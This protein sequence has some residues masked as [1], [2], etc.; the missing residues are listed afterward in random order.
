M[1]RF[2]SLPRLRNQSRRR[3]LSPLPATFVMLAVLA[4]CPHRFDS[5]ADPIPTTAD[6]ATEREYRDARARY[7]AGDHAD[8][9]QRYATFVEHHPDDSLARSAK[10]GE[11]RSRIELG[12]LDKAKELLTPVAR[13]DD[14]IDL[15]ADPLVARARFLLG[16]ALV[17]TGAFEKGRAL[18]QSFRDLSVTNEDQIELHALF[19]A[20]ALGLGESAEALIELDRFYGNA[21]PAERAYI[22]GKA[23]EVAPKLASEDLAR[24]WNGPRDVVL[25]A[26]VGARIAD[27]QRRAGDA[28]AAS[29]IDDQ[30]SAARRKLGTETRSGSSSRP[31]KA[32]I[33]CV[34]PLSG[35]L[36]SLGDRALRGVLLGAELVGAAGGQGQLTVEVRDTGS[37]PQRVRAAMEELAQAGVLAVV[38]PPDRASA[39]EAS[40]AAMTLGLPLFALGPDDS[41]ASSL[42]FHLARPRADAARAAA[43]LIADAHLAR[44]AVLAPDGASGR[45][46][47]RVFLEA[48]RA[49]GLNIVAELHFA[50]N[51]TSFA[52]EVKQ[53][54][55]ARPQ[56]LFLPATAAQ[57]DLIA[58]QLATSGLTAMTNVKSSGHELRVFATADGLSTRNLARSGKYLQ[59]ATLLPPYWAEPSDPRA[60]AFLEHY[61]EAYTEEPSVLD[62]LAFDAVRAVRV[63]VSQGQPE[64]W[65]EVGTALHSVEAGGL[66]GPL[67]FS[68]EGQRTGEVD[69]WVVEGEALKPRGR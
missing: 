31:L 19:A 52:R 61:H 36:K 3:R 33:G 11:A 63:I 5:R 10:V 39:V 45:E 1:V 66:T 23:A 29:R 41:R 58:P 42:L 60:A 48:A 15:R 65:R 62:A 49:R 44:V 43:K 34:L 18:L 57:L 32:A 16:A 64:S 53:I 2:P 27:E 47:A 20:A 28:A 8:A 69:A 55:A 26:F 40:S 13:V 9:A 21:R 12:Q 67:A 14:S 59:G 24:L 4:G 7:E 46:L 51:A 22:L 68:P 6:P 35:K 25:T 37:D 54:D 17:R 56:A 38:G 50:D 30:V